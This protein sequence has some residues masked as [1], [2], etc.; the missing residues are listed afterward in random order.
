MSLCLKLKISTVSGDTQQQMSHACVACLFVC[1]PCAA[2]YVDEV[3]GDKSLWPTNPYQKALG[4][5]L[6]SNFGSEV[7]VNVLLSLLYIRQ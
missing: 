5:L 1:F 2:D 7:C 6:V 4:K 3:F